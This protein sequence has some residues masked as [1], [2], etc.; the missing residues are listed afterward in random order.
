MKSLDNVTIVVSLTCHT[1]TGLHHNSDTTMSSTTFTLR[2]PSEQSAISKGLGQSYRLLELPPELVKIFEEKD[3]DAL[4]HLTIRGRSTDDAVLCT[5]T[6]TYSIRS[7]A[8][9]NSI[10]VVTAA[11]DSPEQSTN[12]IIQDQLSEIMELVPIV[13]KLSR[14][15][16]LLREC[17][18][19]EDEDQ[20][21]EDETMEDEEGRPTKK[22]RFT[23]EQVRGLVQASDAE[24]ERGLREH[25]ILELDGSLRLL[26]DSQLTR[27]LTLILTTLVS[28]N[29]SH[30]SPIPVKKL[31]E[32]LFYEHE[33]AQ[34]LTPQV[35]HWFG[36]VFTQNGEEKWTM[37][38]E[39]VVRQ[40]GL[41]V[42]IQ[43]RNE[44][45]TEEE[46][47]REWKDQVGDTFEDAIKL[48]LLSGNYVDTTDPS[49][50][51]SV[52]KPRYKYFPASQLPI[53]PSQRFADLFLTRK[54]WRAEE[55]EPFLRDI[56]VDKK[57]RDKLLIKFTR[58]I[59][60]ANGVVR[61]T[62]RANY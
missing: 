9:S 45:L 34:N 62:A 28:Q 4:S 54:S 39:K 6:K 31:T 38:V 12:L 19:K 1:F 61:Y 60:D 36:D 51:S 59:T 56:A 48:E 23:Y 27:I 30:K 47:C 10:L 42:L 41:S 25:H 20:D 2:F 33:V 35:C 15:T 8:Q 11:K 3:S 14:L 43:H 46:I 21:D 49:Y 17:A 26:P 57:E 55:L 29:L 16:G 50:A 40:I 32:E 37:D 58:T 22:R 5:R 13:P 44:A 7:V 53:N 18:Y 24:L 52:V